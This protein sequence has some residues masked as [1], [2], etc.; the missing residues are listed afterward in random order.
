MDNIHTRTYMARRGN[1]TNETSQSTFGR[2]VTLGST[3]GLL[4][5]T[6]QHEISTEMLLDN[7]TNS[8]KTSDIIRSNA[9]YIRICDD[10]TMHGATLL[11]KDGPN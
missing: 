10:V 9:C 6:G 4:R 8:Y 7:T 2:N 11:R 1:S 5:N 3:A